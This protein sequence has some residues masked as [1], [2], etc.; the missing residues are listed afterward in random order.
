MNIILTGFYGEGNLGDEAILEALCRNIPDN[1]KIRF[2]SGKFH[3]QARG[4]PIRRRG[5]LSWPKFVTSLKNSKHCIF[6]GGILQDWSFEG[7]SFFA[8]RILAA[9]VAGAQPS[10]WGAGL[11]PIKRPGLRPLAAKALR[12]VE[13]A[14]LRDQYSV[15]E[16][17]ELTG[18]KAQLGTDWSWDLGIETASKSHGNAL[19]INIRPWFENEWQKNL[20][21]QLD[22]KSE[23]RIAIGARLEDLKLLKTLLP[24]S[25]YLNPGSFEELLRICANLKLGIAMRYHV[26]LAM[27][28]ARIPVKLITY[29]EKV[30]EIAKESNICALSENSLTDFRKAD[31]AFFKTHKKRIEQMKEAFTKFL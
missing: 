14:W 21:I 23:P 20:K 8:L 30:R 27:I 16:F 25:P 4:I 22:V 26:A 19:G 24:G 13:A 5:L 29:D 18:K 9:K 28:R 3:K 1:A 12:R 15:N 17:K 31:N 10:L 7:V 11:G 6:S 2:T